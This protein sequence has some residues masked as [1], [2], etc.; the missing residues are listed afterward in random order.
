MANAFDEGAE[1]RAHA[2][3]ESAPSLWGWD[4]EHRVRA[5]AKAIHR[6]RYKLPDS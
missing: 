4:S 3:S 1:S 2:W 5:A 6:I